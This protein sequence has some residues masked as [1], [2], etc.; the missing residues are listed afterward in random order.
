MVDGHGGHGVAAGARRALWITLGLN[1]AL[2][3]VEVAAG[4]AFS[5][6]ALLADAAHE[7]SD[8]VALG[9][10]LVAQALMTRAGSSRHTYG[11]RRAEALG[12]QVNAVLLLGAAVWVFVEAAQRLESPEAVDGAGVIAIASIALMVNVGSAI[13]LGR[14]RARDLNLRGA[15]LHMVGDAAGSIGALLAGIAVV[16]FD[17]TRADA[18]ASIF[19]GVFIVVS[20]FSLLRDTTNVLLEGA[21]RNL[22]LAAVE[23]ALLRES[24]VEAVHHLH[25]WELGSDLPALSVHVVLEGEPTLHDAQARGDTLKAMLS[26]Q[27][28]IEH[29]TV[30]LECHDCE[31]ATSV[32]HDPSAR[33]ATTPP[34]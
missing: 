9:V 31:S 4:M 30:E 13:A 16:A 6:L 11:L 20:A 29:S 25:V 2:L 10:A 24:G 34:G 17:A 1:A 15:W 7:G 12:A 22:D 21:P 28:G 3:V 19:I 27:F 8:V 5:S 23:G 32:L 14:V 18:I 33:G 26:A